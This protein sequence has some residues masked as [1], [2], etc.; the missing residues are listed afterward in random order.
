[1]PQEH[2]MSIKYQV[3]GNIFREITEK[4]LCANVNEY[5]IKARRIDTDSAGNKIE[6]YLLNDGRMFIKMLTGQQASSVME[7]SKSHLMPTHRAVPGLRN[8]SITQPR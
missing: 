1:M 5:L 4:W 7:E 6:N 2:A 3:D 8:Q